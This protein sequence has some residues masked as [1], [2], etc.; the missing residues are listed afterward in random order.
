MTEKKSYEYLK[1]L[2]AQVVQQCEEGN[3]IAQEIAVLLL[4]NI[5][6]EPTPPKAVITDLTDKLKTTRNMFVF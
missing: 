6:S 4:R 2:L 5:A 3:R 1:E